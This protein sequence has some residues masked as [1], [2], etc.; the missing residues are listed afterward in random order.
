[1]LESAGLTV[2]SLEMIYY[3]GHPSSMPALFRCEGSKIEK[4]SDDGQ[5][6]GLWPSPPGTFHI[7][8]GKFSYFI[9]RYYRAIK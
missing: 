1:M 5:V 8:I 6:H 4:K 2:K 7:L 3:R 9:I